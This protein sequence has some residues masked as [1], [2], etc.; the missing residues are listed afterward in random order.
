MLF[1]KKGEEKKK[2]YISQD[3]LLEAIALS[4]LGAASLLIHLITNPSVQ[5]VSRTDD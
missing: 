2:N 5:G 4:F 1:T 3:F